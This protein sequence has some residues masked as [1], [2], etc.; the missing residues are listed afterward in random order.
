MPSRRFAKTVA[1]S[2]LVLSASLLMSTAANAQA[3]PG[4][5]DIE[6][7]DSGSGPVTPP[8]NPMFTPSINILLPTYGGGWPGYGF[9]PGY[10]NYGSIP[11]YGVPGT[12]S[13][14]AV[15]Y[16]IHL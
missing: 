4:D 7:A 11:V 10:L 12:S 2:L 6:H 16:T 9:G 15:T 8:S 13:Y 3:G 5:E 1:G 14:G